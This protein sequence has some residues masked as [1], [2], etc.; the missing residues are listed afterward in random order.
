MRGLSPVSSHDYP[1]YK[2]PSKQYETGQLSIFEVITGLPRPYHNSTYC[3]S[4][5]ITSNNRPPIGI[6]SYR[7]SIHLEPIVQG[8]DSRWE[9]SIKSYSYYCTYLVRTSLS[10]V[11][12]VEGLEAG[13][14]ARTGVCLDHCAAE[15]A[16][17]SVSRLKGVC[18]VN[19]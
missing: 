14:A 2:T 4:I 13:H 15:C 7:L 12:Q 18:Y 5:A 9:N 3:R 8:V 17:P 6:G 19:K 1:E 16:T 11:Q 10:Y